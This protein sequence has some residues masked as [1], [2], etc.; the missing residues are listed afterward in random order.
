M[1]QRNLPNN[2]FGVILMLLLIILMFI[3]PVVL[4]IWVLTDI[5]GAPWRVYVPTSML[6]GLLTIVLTV[7]FK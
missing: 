5:L 7:K 4:T 2:A 1:E 3:V 6:V